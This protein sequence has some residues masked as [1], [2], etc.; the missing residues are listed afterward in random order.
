MFLLYSVSKRRKGNGST[1]LKPIYNS[2][3]DPKKT[4]SCD[5]TH[6]VTLSS[7]NMAIKLPQQRQTYTIIGCLLFHVLPPHFSH[8]TPQCSHHKLI[9]QFDHF[10]MMPSH[11][12]NTTLLSHH[13]S[14]FHTTTP[15]CSQ[16]TTPPSF[17]NSIT[18]APCLGGP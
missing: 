3:C 13:I 6:F 11:T 9:R 8:T 10:P 18:E 4:Q 14:L 5:N 15:C 16:P 17:R 2:R 7:R 1:F 12:Y